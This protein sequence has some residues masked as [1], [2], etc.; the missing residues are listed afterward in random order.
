MYTQHATS[1]AREA[2]DYMSLNVNKFVL[3]VGQDPEDE[4]VFVKTSTS[5][6]VHR[7]KTAKDEGAKITEKEFLSSYS[8]GRY[9][10]VLG[11][12]I[13]YLTKL[14]DGSFKYDFERYPDHWIALVGELEATDKQHYRERFDRLLEIIYD[15]SAFPDK[16]TVLRNT[17]KVFSD[18]MFIQTLEDMKN[19]KDCICHR[20]YKNLVRRAKPE[21]PVEETHI[22]CMS[23]ITMSATEEENR[24]ISWE[25]KYND[26]ASSKILYCPFCGR[27]LE[28]E[29]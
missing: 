24:S 25:I 7:L 13:K 29:W 3:A 2:L 14:P 19:N 15:K 12:R 21:K 1:N 28:R 8:Q 11:H 17:W 27:K 23:S 16:P 6:F 26:S 5:S 4:F 9:S 10:F 22:T 20:L 18:A